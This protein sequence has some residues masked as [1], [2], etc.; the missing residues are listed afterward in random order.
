MIKDKRLYIILGIVILFFGLLI[1]V[2]Y[3]VDTYL[4]F[5]SPK[6][7]YI[8]EYIYNG[9]I[10]TYVFLFIMNLLKIPHYIIYLLSYLMAIIMLT[11]S[12]YELNKTLD[13]YVSNKI[14]STLLS[15]VIL[16]NPF[17]IELWLFIE[18]G[19]MMLSIFAIIMAFKYFDLYIKN[20]DKKKLLY[21]LLWNIVA[22]FS[23][24]G[25]F[26]L[27]MILAVFSIIMNLK[28]KKDLIKNNLYALALY[29]IPSIINYIFIIIFSTRRVG[30]V[31]NISKT[32][33]TIISAT[34][35]LIDGF[36][37]FPKGFTVIFLIIT[38]IITSYY[39]L[40][41]KK[42]KKLFI[43]M[44][45]I[46]LITYVFTILPII[47]QTGERI[48]IYPRTCYAF[49]SIVGILYLII[50]NK[51]NTKILST[52]I[53]IFL[54]MELL[55][56]TRLEINRYK[57][58][59]KDKEIV[60]KIEEKVREYE[61]ANNIKVDKLAIYNLKNSKKF[62][63]RLNDNI[64]VSAIKENPSGIATYTYYTNRHLS[65]TNSSDDVYNN[66]FKNIDSHNFSLDQVVII[67]N[68]IHWYLY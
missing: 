27:F 45:Y 14:L 19:F 15:I 35:H 17:I 48:A 52:L 13:N 4:M 61:N 54:G 30:G 11:K 56:F 53:I 25:T 9:R 32:F 57:V 18:T 12:I 46:I 50:N 6:M 39:I 16:V 28:N 55:T 59:E 8:I 44:I 36:G 58:N 7:G 51:K 64:N 40:T 47:P 67:D 29:G 42:Q 31:F 22:I 23:Y 2:N 65:Y 34:T 10:F 5:S 60:L 21:T 68:T 3:S 41:N 66:Y 26:A 20:N 43:Y 62:Y 49:F 24:Q 1:K 38:I 33:N 37:L 63:D